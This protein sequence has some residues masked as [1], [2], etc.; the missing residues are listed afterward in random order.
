[1]ESKKRYYKENIKDRMF[2]NAANFWGVRNVENLD[3][4]VKL[5]I[6]ALASEI[7]K[8]SNEI[9]NIETRI[10]ERIAHLLTPDI[11]MS[12]RPAHM[13]LYTQPLEIQ[14]VVNKETGFYYDDP[15]FKQRNKVSDVSFYPVDIFPLIKAQVKAMVCG[16]SVY[17]V[18]DT[19]NKEILTRSSVKTEDLSQ[20]IWIGIQLDPALETLSDL[21]FYFDF[22]N[23]ENKNEYF[24]L[25]P[26]TRW[27]HQSKPIRMSPGIYSL[28]DENADSGDMSLFSNYNLAY[29][30]DDGIKRFYNHRFLTIKDKLK[31]SD[32][33]KE[34]FPPEVKPYF[35]EEAI[36]QLTEPLYWLRV[37]FPPSFDEE[38]IDRTIA[39]VNVFPVANKSLRS[40]SSGNQKLANIIPL[41]TDDKEYFLSVLSVTDSHNRHYKQLPFKDTEAQQYGTYSV[42]RGGTERFDARDAKEYISQLVD[43]LRDEGAAFSLIGKGFLEDMITDVESLIISLEQKLNDIHQNREIPSYLIIDSENKNE[44]IFVDYWVTNCEMVNGIKA[45]TFF[46]PYNETFVDSSLIVSLTP[47]TG[48]KGKPKPSNILDIYKYILTSRNRIYTAED[49][50]N[51]CHNEFGDIIATAEVKKG[52][53][54]SS[55]PKEG[56][57]RTIDVFVNPKQNFDPASSEDLK[58][59]LHNLLIERSPDTFNYR[60]FVNK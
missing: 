54:V 41:E 3:P 57:I 33:R 48:G 4:L 2:K 17:T 13:L 21:S 16:K 30:S 26:F 59:N 37:N 1:M 25:L 36:A 51:F 28:K 31:V 23:I 9:N 12:A 39:S 58:S 29:I 44:I 43:L 34:I 19:L 49:I 20:S 56:L 15:V 60:I 32:M 7:Y 45:G 10:L 24:H 22:I 18:D 50:I 42:K 47:C 35:S 14:G 6:E 8:L 52:V 27:E 38:I 5:L 55:K 53:Q 11:L 46:A 40:Q